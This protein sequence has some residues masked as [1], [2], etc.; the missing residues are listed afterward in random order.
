MRACALFADSRTLLSSFDCPVHIPGSI[1]SG[2][3]AFRVR[4]QKITAGRESCTMI[5]RF[6]AGN[7]QSSS[8]FLLVLLLVG[9]IAPAFAQ[10]VQFDQ[11]ATPTIIFGD[12]NDNGAFTTDRRKDIEIAIRGKLRFNDSGLPENTFNSNGD[13]SYSFDA[14]VAPTQTSP[15][16]EWAFDW[17]V[18]SDYTDSA[19]RNLDELVYEIGLDG[20]P[21]VGTDF[22]VFDPIT[23]SNEAPFFD[24]AIGNNTTGNGDGTVATDGTSYQTLLADNNVAQN[25]WRY[26]FFNGDGTALEN[27]DPTV[28]GRYA[29]YIQAMDPTT[30]EVLARSYIQILAGDAPKPATVYVDADFAGANLGDT[31]QFTMPGGGTVEAEFGVDAFAE[32]QNAVDAVEENGTVLMGSDITEDL[33]KVDKAI[34]LDGNGFTL[35]STSDNFGVSI[36]SLDATIENLIVDGAGT[37][38]IHQSPGSDNLVIRGTTVQN[39]GGS[40]FAMNCSNNILLQNI[41]AFDN[42]GNGVS[43]TNCT[44]VVIDGITT[45]GNQFTTFSAGIG[46]FSSETTCPPE[47]TDGVEI[48]DSANISE[49]VPVYTQVS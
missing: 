22:L 27:F 4:I 12:G 26:D 47:G 9:C 41:S 28:N 3:S 49:P 7:I 8:F 15:T 1:R 24:H 11:D 25:S 46:I 45:S 2:I 10:T 13:G 35:S 16:P 39:G 42:G 40:G 14:I 5:H 34:T 18:N 19:G 36:Q 6:I 32:L 30:N 20:D 23:P 48:T 44:D 31:V 43:I 37:F 21:G 29:V 17:S 38:G 33:V